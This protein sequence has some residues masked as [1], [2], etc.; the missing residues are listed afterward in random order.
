MCESLNAQEN[1]GPHDA[2]RPGDAERERALIE[3]ARL[4]E[5]DAD[6]TLDPRH[7]TR[8]RLPSAIGGYKVIRE[9][10][11]GGMGVVYEAVQA[12]PRRNVAIK[13]LRGGHADDDHRLRLFRR[14]IR[15]LARLK[16]PDI[17]TIFEAGRT[18]DGQRFLVMELVRG[19]TLSR[20]LREYQPS[21]EQQLALFARICRAV[22]YANQH[23]V[24]HRDLKPSNILVCEE[25]TEARRH[26]GTK[27]D[28][29]K[30]K[31][32]NQESK[33]QP[34]ILD[35]G[36]ARITDADLATTVV[37]EVGK[38]QGTLP[39]MSPEQ[40][41][42]DP[43]DIDVRTD[44]YALG[45]ILYEMVT[46]RYPYP[47]S[48]SVPQTLKH[49]T[50][51]PVTPPRM[52]ARRDEPDE[53]ESTGPRP[54]HRRID[55]DL[56]TIM[57]RTLAKE[58][59]RRYQSA[60]DLASDVERYLAGAP[61]EAK[62]DRLWYVLRKRAARH[63]FAIVAAILMLGVLA[64]AGFYSWRTS[65]DE[66]LARQREVIARQR[67][68]VRALLT[69]LNTRRP[70]GESEHRA[71]LF[72]VADRIRG[73]VASTLDL[74]AFG[75]AFVM[76]EFGGR[77]L[78]T[79]AQRRTISFTV[80][81]TGQWAN[82]AD[83]LGIL[84]TPSIELDGAPVEWNRGAGPFLLCTP[85]NAANG[86]YVDSALGLGPHKLEGHVEVRAVRLLDAARGR[87]ILRE[88][89]RGEEYEDIT[90]D[91]IDLSLSPLTFTAVREYP[92]NYPPRIADE[93]VA[94]AIDEG[95]EL[96]RIVLRGMDDDTEP[97]AL[98]VLEAVFPR[99]DI[100]LACAVAVEVPDGSWRARFD[101]VVTS[102]RWSVSRASLAGGTPSIRLDF[103][104][105]VGDRRTCTLRC[106]FPIASEER[107]LFDEG[108]PIRFTMRAEQSVAR[109]FPIVTE[110]LDCELER[111][112]KIGAD[113]PN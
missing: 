86:G 72:S 60:G 111:V 83:G 19:P 33:A 66:Q 108:T 41:R 69:W 34:K 99:P 20:F 55:D 96:R 112:G 7:F 16:S 103:D 48:R 105:P 70:Q 80:R 92:P 51:T 38:I 28:N 27:A 2:D 67:E 89:I 63:R 44:V 104:P 77:S 36:L 15:A 31:T 23:G 26:E 85:A 54:R 3:A 22:H 64:A 73:G 82:A 14:E 113:A 87:F 106:E 13:V 100:T 53:G 32:Q 97:A 52:A 49:I 21:L 93:E 57:L 110:Y 18:D 102:E 42:G 98:L 25:G 81:S 75:R 17:A 88:P 94:R 9:L 5:S 65:R 29:P 37:T 79:E 35:F 30:S 43:S 10:G 11:R 91:A 40:A 71:V 24:I 50:E 8:G 1:A 58:P 76:C 12:D 95:F 39:Y 6:G 4:Q 59:E 74:M 109:A 68:E 61:I 84:F 101:L 56:R 107:T 46:G 45:V 62:R 47:I 90:S 78:V